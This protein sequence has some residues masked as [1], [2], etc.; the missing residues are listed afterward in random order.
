MYTQNFEVECSKL[1]DALSSGSWPGLPSGWNNSQDAYALQY[2][3]EATQQL[4]L[5]KA[6]L[7]EGQLLV[8]GMV[9]NKVYLTVYVV[10]L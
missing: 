10:R 6:I 7:M 5:I 3:H 2:R 4:C 9:N 8:N 1:A